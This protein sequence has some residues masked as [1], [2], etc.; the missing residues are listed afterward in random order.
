MCNNCLNKKTLIFFLLIFTFFSFLNEKLQLLKTNN[1]TEKILMTP[2]PTTTVLEKVKVVRVI[3]G[4]TIEIENSQ[5]VRY[6]GINTPELHDKRKPV[7]CF[8]NEAYLKNKELVEGK[9]VYLEKDVSHTDKY[10]R[11]LRYV[12]LTDKSSTDEANFINLYLIA[13]GYANLMTVPPDVKHAD[14]FKQERKKA[15]INN[16]GLWNKCL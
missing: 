1:T 13:N 12:Y 15:M 4:D 11:L 9:E 8:A 5:K 10:G 7:E 3:D 16:L 14:L 2:M 6:I